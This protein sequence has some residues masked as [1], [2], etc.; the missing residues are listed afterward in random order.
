MSFESSVFLLL[1]LMVF[2]VIEEEQNFFW[3]PFTRTNVL[4]TGQ[5]WCVPN[6]NE[7]WPTC[8]GA[9]LPR[10][11]ETVNRTWEVVL[12]TLTRCN[13]SHY[14]Y[15]RKFLHSHLTDISFHFVQPSHC[16]LVVALRSKWVRFVRLLGENTRFSRHPATFNYRDDEVS[17]YIYIMFIG[18]L[19]FHIISNQGL[20]LHLLTFL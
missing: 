5:E 18:T 15:L 20:W 12:F 9:I 4:I 17:I 11:W 16:V 1:L 3:N 2:L 14:P 8:M 19:R 6:S 13:F 10:L 7:V